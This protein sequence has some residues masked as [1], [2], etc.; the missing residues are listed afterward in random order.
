MMIQFSSKAGPNITMFERDAAR[1]LRMMGHSGTI[2]SAMLADDIDAALGRLHAALQVA[3]GQTEGPDA[4][5]GTSDAEEEHVDLKVRAY[6]LI[7]LFEAALASGD[8]VMWDYFD[9]TLV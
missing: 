3:A 2:P 6:P 1:L 8:A 5:P 7:R 4:G 9:G